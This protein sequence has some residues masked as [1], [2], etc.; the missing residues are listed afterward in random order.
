MDDEN[1]LELIELAR[2]N[3]VEG[4]TDAI[5]SAQVEVGGTPGEKKTR[6]TMKFRFWEDEGKALQDTIAEVQEQ[7]GLKT[8]DEAFAFI[9]TEFK[10]AQGGEAPATA[11]P[12]QTSA[13]AAAKPAAK[14]TAK[15]AARPARQ[16]AAAA[17]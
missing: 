7:Q 4:L 16:A 10:M 15:P 11:A 8:P 14:T 17:A 1:A 6:V 5:K 9:V 2:T 12:Q 3:T 13:R